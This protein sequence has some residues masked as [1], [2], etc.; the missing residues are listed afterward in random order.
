MMVR[1]LLLIALLLIL[2][3]TA[4]AQKV[5]EISDFKITV[6]V[7]SLAHVRYDITLKNLIDKPVVPGIGEIRLQKVEPLKVAFISVPF[8]EQRKAVKVSDVKAYSDG[9]T[10]KVSVEEKEDYTVIVY[11]IWYP[12]EPGK[13]LSFTVEYNA[14]IVDSGLLFKSVTIPI[15]TDTDIRNLEI[16]VNSNWKLTFAE[17]PAGN[18]PMWRGSLPAGSIAFY[19][20]EFSMLPLPTMPV[21]GYVVI[22]GALL[23]L[24]LILL[25]IGLRR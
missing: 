7:N 3:V 23:G 22:W 2:P 1:K 13:T 12:I 20:A 21:R 4:Q 8:T 14:D 19:T 15:G 6:D 16:N 5:E 25:V 17:P 9:K 24:F 18:S 10:F 11:E